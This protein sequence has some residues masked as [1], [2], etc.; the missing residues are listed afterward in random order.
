MILPN[1]KFDILLIDPPWKYAKR[2]N[3]RTKF[4]LG[5]SQRDLLSID[6]MKAL[7]VGN[8]CKPRSLVFMW[9][10]MPMLDDALDIMSTWGF[11]Y[12]TVGFTWIKVNKIDRK[13]VF[14]IGFYTKSNAELCLLGGRGDPSL[15][16]MNNDVSSVI[17]SPPLEFGYKPEETYER[18]DR[19]YPD[20]LKVELFA[21]RGHEG[22]GWTQ[23]KYENPSKTA[24]Q[25]PGAKDMETLSWRGASV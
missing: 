21:E 14:G 18:I 24:Y 3:R 20:L 4:G 19:M 7:P 5:A 6:E 12:K 25:K 11:E 13:P 1:A 2:S 17:L 23:L 15:K 9:T 8:V 16:P 10:T 22:P